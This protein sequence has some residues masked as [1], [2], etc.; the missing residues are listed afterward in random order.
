[1][2]FI[3]VTEH[4]IEHGLALAREAMLHTSAAGFAADFFHAI[5]GNAM[6]FAETWEHVHSVVVSYSAFS[7]ALIIY[8]DGHR[9]KVHRA[10]VVT[11]SA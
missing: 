1:M 2:R 8:I 5:L 9:E 3:Q 6:I 11:A 7:A 10:H 4:R